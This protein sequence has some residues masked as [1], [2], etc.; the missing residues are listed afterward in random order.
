MNDT[1]HFCNGPNACYLRR[2]D[3]GKWQDACFAC[4]KKP[5][6]VPKNFQKPAPPPQPQ[7]KGLF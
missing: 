4:A 7:Q 1:C 3:S 6:P 2:D 5:Y